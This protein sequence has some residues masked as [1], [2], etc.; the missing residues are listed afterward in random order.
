MSRG[1]LRLGLIGCWIVSALLLA[2]YV[3]AQLVADEP[4]R[5]VLPGMA[6]LFPVYIAAVSPFCMDAWRNP[7]LSKV[8]AG[9][10]IWAI[11]YLPFV[12]A[13]AYWYRHPA[14]A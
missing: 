4:A 6:V 9:A 11:L 13:T 12:S 10:W 5:L 14:T 8:A 2:L 1:S 7:H 3:T